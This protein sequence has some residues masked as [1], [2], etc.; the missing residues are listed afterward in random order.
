M[1]GPT[2]WPIVRLGSGPK[3][4][5]S[6]NIGRQLAKTSSVCI[7]IEIGRDDIFSQLVELTNRT[8]HTSG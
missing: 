6:T 2:L 7:K 8:F 1:D 3:N 5:I 4:Q